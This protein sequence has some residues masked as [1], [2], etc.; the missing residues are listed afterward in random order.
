MVHAIRFC[1]FMTALLLAESSFA[2][3]TD[4]EIRFSTPFEKHTLENGDEYEIRTGRVKFP[5]G[6]EAFA[7]DFIPHHSRDSDSGHGEFASV[8]FWAI[9]QAV[10][11]NLSQGLLR[12][13]VF[14]PNPQL[15]ALAHRP[16][17]IL[18]GRSLWL[19][20]DGSLT[21]RDLERGFQ[22]Q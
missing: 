9:P 20:P 19:H 7:V 6:I 16:C 12:A 4:I 8:W 11:L 2:Q 1:V 18:S 21:K 3:Q 15:N 14:G 13:V 22:C 5:D 17:L 10:R